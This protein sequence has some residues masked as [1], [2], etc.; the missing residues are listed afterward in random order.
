[1]RVAR[2]WPDADDR[3][4]IG[5]EIV[6]REVLQDAGLHRRLSGVTL[7]PNLPADERPRH[8]VSGIRKGRGFQV[9][10]PLGVVPGRFKLL[11]QIPRGDDFRTERLDE[12][13]RPG[14][15]P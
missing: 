14:I 8:A 7:P 4:M 12:F 2:V 13:H 3:G 11:N 9:H 15:D 10:R 6:V 1:M 5:N